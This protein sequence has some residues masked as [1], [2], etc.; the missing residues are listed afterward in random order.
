MLV[1]FEVVVARGQDPDNLLSPEVVAETQAQVMTLDEAS[2]L[3][4]SG[5]RA[6]PQ[7]LQVRLVAV[8]PR[9]ARFVQSR[10]E[11]NHAV[12]SFRAHEVD[13]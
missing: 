7:G 1:L 13:M 5:A 10:L 11:A 4:F 6:D 3:G 8:A 12:A 2:A 9:D